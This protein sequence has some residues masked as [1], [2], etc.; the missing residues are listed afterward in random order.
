MSETILII[1]SVVEIVALVIVLAVYL[2]VIAGQLRSIVV[3]LQEVSW[4]AHAVERQLLA[5]RP[6]VSKVNWALEEIVS[7]VPAAADKAERLARNRS[8]MVGTS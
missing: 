5:V 1:L 8:G 3:T 4:G 2:L 7:T 6:N